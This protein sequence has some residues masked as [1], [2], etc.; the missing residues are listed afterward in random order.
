MIR[1]S[2]IA[3]P[4]PD[5]NPCDAPRSLAEVLRVD[6]ELL[7]WRGEPGAVSAA[8]TKLQRSLELACQQA[9]LSWELRMALELRPVEN[10]T[11]SARRRSRASRTRI[12]QIHGGLWNVGFAI[13]PSNS[14]ISPVGVTMSEVTDSVFRYP[15]QL[16]T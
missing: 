6:A 1:D 11:G 3:V 9:A 4:F 14:R 13:C 2:S 16:S 12:Q 5:D 8:E 15:D 10:R 7:L